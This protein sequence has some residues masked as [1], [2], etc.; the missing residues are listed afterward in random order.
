MAAASLYFYEVGQVVGGVGEALL[1]QQPSL[2]GALTFDIAI[3]A[4]SFC[5]VLGWTV[6]MVR[7]KTTLSNTHSVEK[8]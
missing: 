6:S 8:R 3:G 2:R 4:V 5:F 7:R 1:V